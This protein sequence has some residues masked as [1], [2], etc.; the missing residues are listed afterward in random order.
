MKWPWKPESLLYSASW[1]FGLVFWRGRCIP[2]LT[3]YGVCIYAYVCVCLCSQ[4]YPCIHLSITPANSQGVKTGTSDRLSGESGRGVKE[5]PIFIFF[6]IIGNSLVNNKLRSGGTVDHIKIYISEHLQ[7]YQ[8]SK[9]AYI[10]I[11]NQRNAYMTWAKLASS[12]TAA[13]LLK[14]T[15]QSHPSTWLPQPCKEGRRIPPG[16]DN[17]FTYVAVGH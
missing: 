13:F 1:Q 12:L 10:Q 7:C 4:A 11:C 6:G 8:W 5:R 16:S 3:G 2:S 14:Q 9:N 15:D 17:G